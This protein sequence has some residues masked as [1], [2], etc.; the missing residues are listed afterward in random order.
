VAFDNSVPQWFP[1]YVR[2]RWLDTHSLET[3]PGCKLDEQLLFS[4]GFEWGYWLNDVTALRS[5]YD[6]YDS[7]EAMIAEQLGDATAAFI[8]SVADLQHDALIDLKL[9]PYLASRDV[10]I[11]SGRALGVVSQPDRVTYDQLVASADPVAFTQDVLTPLVAYADLIGQVAPPAGDDRWTAELRDGLAIDQLRP[12]FMVATY[13]AVLAHL[14]GDDAEAAAQLATARQLRADA[15]VVV[16]RRHANMHDTHGRRL[17]DKGLNQTFYQYG[18]LR[19][20]D[21]LCF[22][23]RELAQ[24]DGILGNTTMMPP[25]CLF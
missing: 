24:V 11:D 15:Q 4:S 23:D 21:I 16:A 17:L 20:A 14:R 13:Q 1:L 19:N 3:M 12:R 18:Y 7:Y 10:A 9:A 8:T 2:S 22:W 6:L 25:G 5:S